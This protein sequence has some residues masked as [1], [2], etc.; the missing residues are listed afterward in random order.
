MHD[1]QYTRPKGETYVPEVDFS[2]DGFPRPKAIVIVKRGGGHGGYRRSQDYYGSDGF[3][4]KSK[5][6]FWNY[7]GYVPYWFQD[8]CEAIWDRLKLIIITAIISPI[9]F[10]KLPIL[11][12]FL[13]QP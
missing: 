9:L 11:L 8:L 4:Q 10:E 13:F 5:G 12:R 6:K 1:E 7:K 3:R 2:R